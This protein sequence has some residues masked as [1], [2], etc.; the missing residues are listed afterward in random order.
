MGQQLHGEDCGAGAG[1]EDR[2]ALGGL[3]A[4]L[5]LR[6]NCDAATKFGEFRPSRSRRL[7]PAPPPPDIHLLLRRTLELPSSPQVPAI[8]SKAGSYL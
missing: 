8:A 7:W 3:E 4:V 2:Q 1:R 6:T 5:G